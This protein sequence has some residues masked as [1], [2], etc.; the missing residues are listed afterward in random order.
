[1]PVTQARLWVAHTLIATI[2][3]G[4][5]ACIV[6]HRDFWPLLTYP[7]YAELVQGRRELCWLYGESDAH[8][9]PLHDDRYWHP[10]DEQRLGVGLQQLADRPRG[11]VLVREA[12]ARLAARYERARRA[13][14]HDGPELDALRVYAVRWDLRSGRPTARA[15]DERVQIGEFRIDAER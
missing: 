7:M 14:Q 4:S 15:P 5:L 1:L 11:A 9:A 12:L 10:A 13:G 3:L 6:T 2:G 8:E